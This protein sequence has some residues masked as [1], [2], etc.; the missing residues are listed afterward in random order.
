MDTFTLRLAN[1]TDAPAISALICNV[2]PYLTLHPAGRGVGQFLQGMTAPAIARYIRESGCH[3]Q[4]GLV[5]SVLAGV[6][7]VSE[8]THVFH[9]F[10][11]PAF[12]HRGVAR[13]LWQAAKSAAIE[14][15]N[16]Q[17]FTVNS[18]PY[19]QP[20]YERFGFIVTGP[21]MSEHGI[22][23]VPMRLHAEP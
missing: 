23:C 10:V 6:I 14:A 1:S 4:L 15:G 21:T 7:A 11:A 22:A 8:N 17:G 20:M 5:E 16:T 13:R 2:A 12:H 18:S 9:L 19:A 3:Y